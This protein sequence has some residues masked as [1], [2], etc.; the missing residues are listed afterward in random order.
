MRGDLG[1]VRIG[2]L[3]RFEHRRLDPHPVFVHRGQRQ[4]RRPRA[5]TREDSARH[6]AKATREHR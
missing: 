1:E 6:V 3:D 2:R 4:Q 5:N